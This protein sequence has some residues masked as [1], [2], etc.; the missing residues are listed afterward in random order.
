MVCFRLRKAGGRGGARGIQERK[1]RQK[2]LRTKDNR[3]ELSRR[4]SKVGEMRLQKKG[5]EK[6]EEDTQQTTETEMNLSV[7]QLTWQVCGNLYSDLNALK[8]LWFFCKRWLI[9]L[10]RL[11]NNILWYSA[12]VT[13]L[14]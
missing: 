9:I 1:R 4:P 2:N 5:N 13:G 12:D 11:K 10:I 14:K 7:L 3:S 6:I 8:L